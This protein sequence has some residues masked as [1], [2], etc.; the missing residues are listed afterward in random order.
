MVTA[1]ARQT[2]RGSD[3]G[4][5]IVVVDSTEPDRFTF[6]YRGNRDFPAIR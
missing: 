1:A 2:L 4:K 6:E 5:A 3:P